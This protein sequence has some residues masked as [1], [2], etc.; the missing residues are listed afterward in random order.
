[1]NPNFM[2]EAIR[3]SK[4]KSLQGDG[5][6]FGAVIVKDGKIIARG[7]NQVLKKND[8]TCHAEMVAIRKACRRLGNYSLAGCVIYVNC[9]PC[10]MCLSALYWAGVEKIYFAATRRDA[11][12]LGFVD[13]FLYQELLLPPEN[14]KMPMHQVMREQ[15]IAVFSQWDNFA[16]K[17]IY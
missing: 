12:G 5:G 1:M 13:E 10:P 16:N 2:Q 14:R 4:E 6:P 15:A 7:W 11:A 9:E 17:I 3:L 8:P